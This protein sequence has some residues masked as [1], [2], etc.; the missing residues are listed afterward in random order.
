M[1]LFRPAV[2]LGIAEFQISSKFFEW[3]IWSLPN[4]CDLLHWPSSESDIGRPEGKNH[5][6]HLPLKIPCDAG[7][8]PVPHKY[9][10]SDCPVLALPETSKL[11]TLSGF[12]CA[13]ILKG[14]SLVI[15][16][17][18]VIVFI[19]AHCCPSPHF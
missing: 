18:L 12:S 16:L 8:Q 9:C 14:F 15:F 10:L 11:S 4:S 6:Y 1:K 7:T 3:P 17:H 13:F 5:H 2:C 19:V